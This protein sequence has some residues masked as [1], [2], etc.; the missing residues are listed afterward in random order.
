VDAEARAGGDFPTYA[1]LMTGSDGAGTN[2][3]YLAT[4]DA[5]K[6]LKDLESRN[7]VV[8]VVGNFGGPK[9]LRSV[10]SYLRRQGAT[11]SAFYVSNVEQYLREDGI[12]GNFCANA[13]TLPID[14]SS[15]FIRSARGVLCGRNGASEANLI[16]PPRASRPIWRR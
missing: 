7:L 12:W 8:P 2:R 1:D 16:S 4:E 15:T 6:F 11:V 9:A 14:A 13:A 5:F 3:S 10:G